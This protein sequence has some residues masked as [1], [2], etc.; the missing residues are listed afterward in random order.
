MFVFQLSQQKIPENQAQASKPDLAT[1]GA[2]SP[3]SKVGKAFSAF[4]DLN[5]AKINPVV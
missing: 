3:Q 2:F 5:L 1:I 4:V